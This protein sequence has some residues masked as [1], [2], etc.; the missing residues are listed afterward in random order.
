MTTAT[1]N[2]TASTRAQRIQHAGS[3]VLAMTG[4][5]VRLVIRDPDSMLISLVLPITIMVMFVYVLGGAID[6]GMD[7]ATY[8]TP[9]V[10]LLCAGYGASNT[11]IA[12]AE[13]MIGGAMDRFRSMPI[14]GPAVLAGH[15]IAS[16]AKNLVTTA[17]VLVVATLLGFEP[18]ASLLEWLGA[19]GVIALYI[20]AITCIA[21]YVG[22]IVRTP[23]AAGGFGFF[24]LFLP[25]IS[26]AFAPPETMPAWLRG[27]AEHQPVTPII[28]T[29][30]GLLVGLGSDA[31][32]ATDLGSTALLAIAWCAA[33]M[34]VFLTAAS[35]AFSRR[36]G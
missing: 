31:A 4:R 15:V 29:I 34:V 6:V 18:D 8:A 26:S 19:I 32:P 28:E 2:P 13:D 7:Y 25:Y 23:A 24:M 27:V 10:I 35:R 33:L 3:D 16:V 21:T 9:G 5:A 36:R 22:V 17:L 30:R 11:A 1:A 20:L 12:V 14:L